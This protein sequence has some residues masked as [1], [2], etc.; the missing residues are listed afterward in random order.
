MVWVISFH[1]TSANMRT[2]KK[3]P[4]TTHKSKTNKI[5][6]FTETQTEGVENQ[7]KGELRSLLI[8]LLSFCYM[9]ISFL[10]PSKGL[11][12]GLNQLILPSPLSKGHQASETPALWDLLS[13]QGGPSMGGTTIPAL[14]QASLQAT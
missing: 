12:E 9:L 4:H 10:G 3:Y 6:S 2:F 7:E 14:F 1:L 5:Y 11:F 13:R 8:C